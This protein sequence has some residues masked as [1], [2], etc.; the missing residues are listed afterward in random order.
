MTTMVS[1][2][3]QRNQP[4]ASSNDRHPLSSGEAHLQ[5]LLRGCGL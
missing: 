1:V 5:L 3:R 4:L 2:D